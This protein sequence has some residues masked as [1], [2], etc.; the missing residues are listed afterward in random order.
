MRDQP[1]QPEIQVEDEA[2]VPE[3][4]EGGEI[5]EGGE[6]LEGGE[7]VEGGEG[8]EGGEGGADEGSAGGD[9]P[10]ADVGASAA[11]GWCESANT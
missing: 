9:K 7:G 4:E 2:P 8:A 5:A 10:T 3:G 1:K 6:G 11:P